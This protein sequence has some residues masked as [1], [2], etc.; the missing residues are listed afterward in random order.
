MTRNCVLGLV[1]L[2]PESPKS[3]FSEV[4]E[5][6]GVEERGSGRAKAA[7]RGAEMPAVL[8]ACAV[9]WAVCRCR[10]AVLSQSKSR[11][12]VGTE[13]Y[14]CRIGFD[15]RVILEVWSLNTGPVRESGRQGFRP[16]K[17]SALC[18]EQGLIPNPE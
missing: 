13:E 4:A 5:E 14:F 8:F 12:E 17:S 9:A 15:M 2:S 1:D 18:E 16:A 3:N 10:S 6:E 11:E 7:E